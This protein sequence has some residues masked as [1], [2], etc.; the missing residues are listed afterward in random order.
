MAHCWNIF[1]LIH[2]CCVFR[3]SQS[4]FTSFLF[5]GGDLRNSLSGL[6]NGIQNGI[7]R[8]LPQTDVPSY[9]QQQQYDEQY[10]S[11]QPSY[12]E[13][14]F[15]AESYPLQEPNYITTQQPKL[16]YMQQTVFENLQ[17]PSFVTVKQPNF[18]ETPQQPSRLFTIEPRK[19]TSL[20]KSELKIVQSNDFEKKINVLPTI[21]SN[22][23]DDSCGEGTKTVSLIVHGK[24]ATKGD[25]PWI[26][27]VYKKNKLSTGNIYNAFK[28]GSTLL[29]EKIVVTVA[30]CVIR[31]NLLPELAEN[32]L[33]KVGAFNLDDEA[34]DTVITRGVYLIKV[35][36]NYNAEL[37]NDIA[38]MVMSQTVQF[39]YYI[40]PICLWP[41]E[42]S[43]KFI[44]GQQGTVVGWGKDET[45]SFSVEPR[46]V[47]VSILSM[48][49]CRNSGKKYFPVTN[50]NT[51]CAGAKDGSGPCNGD[52]GGGLFLMYNNKWYLRGLVSLSITQTITCN[53]DNYVIYTDV[54]KYDS[55]IRARLK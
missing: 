33:L 39:S 47:K 3:L 17:Q 48:E 23:K 38:I 10:L 50:E 4:Q 30:H 26:V 34:D 37:K 21:G 36:E 7:S 9:N 22:K 24:E 53:L 2:L 45:G 20:T 44:D 13:N 12:V 52:S 16:I 19:A 35:H 5:G 14:R 54:A 32:L 41:F 49:R 18:I 27:A 31:P 51:F 15:Q 6:V 28:C 42:D 43:Q 40:R 55:W 25:W 11:A 46:T 29:S 1:I 8:L